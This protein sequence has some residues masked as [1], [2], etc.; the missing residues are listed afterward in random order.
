MDLARDEIRERAHARLGQ[1][2]HG[3]QRR[4]RISLVEILDDGEGLVEARA[5]IEDQGWHQALRI[6]RGVGRLAM[7]ALGEADE[8]RLVGQALEVEGDADAKRGRA[9]EMR[10]QLH[11]AGSIFTL[12]SPTPSTPACISSPGFTG[13]TPAGVPE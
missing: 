10:V 8:H 9:A 13:P 2:L 4:V 1:A 7:L 12:S 6:D 5:V 11:S 3:H